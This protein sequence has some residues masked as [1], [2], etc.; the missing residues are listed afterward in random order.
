MGIDTRILPR[1][2]LAV[3]LAALL[4]PTTIPAATQAENPLVGTL[5]CLSDEQR[6]ELVHRE[7]LEFLGAGK[8]LLRSKHE[9]SEALSARDGAAA[10]LKACEHASGPR[11]GPSCDAERDRLARTSAE[12]QRSQARRE[13]AMADFNGVASS[14]IQVVRAEYPSCDSR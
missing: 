13:K 5:A 3:A 9:A 11:K 12:L 14:R 4:A 8:E 6:T 10:A 7:M 1:C 2:G